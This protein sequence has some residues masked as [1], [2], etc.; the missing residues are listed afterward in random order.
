MSVA[1]KSPQHAFP[2]LDRVPEITMKLIDVTP[3][4]AREWLGRNYEM[5]RHRGRTVVEKYRRL[6]LNDEWQ[7]THQGI[8]FDSDGRLIDGQ[9]RLDALAGLT[10]DSPAVRF[11][12]FQYHTATPPMFALDN[13]RVRLVGDAFEVMGVTARGAGKNI[14]STCASLYQGVNNK[15]VNPDTQ[16]SIRVYQAHKEAIDWACHA[17]HSAYTAPVRAACAY[18]YPVEPAVVSDFVAKIVSK[19]GVAAKSPELALLKKLDHTFSG[20]R[21]RLGGRDERAEVFYWTLAALRA[22]LL[23]RSLEKVYGA[24]DADEAQCVVFFK[25]RRRAL[26]LPEGAEG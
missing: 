6:M 22:R 25:G 14:A 17:V 15:L 24:S 2:L 9:H 13:G 1:Q 20:K 26:G 11:C 4:M 18:A 16:T 21:V 7:T 3:A 12:V 8:A 5:N 10:D 19:V 23:G